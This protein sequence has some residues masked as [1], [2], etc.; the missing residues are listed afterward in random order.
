MSSIIKKKIKG[1]FDPDDLW[2]IFVSNCKK[3]LHLAL[4]MTPIGDQFRQRLRNFPSLINCTS[5][6]WVLPW[7]EE[8][9]TSV[10][11]HFLL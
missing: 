4:C 8:A 3:Y 5:I 1:K 2:E 11:N 9:L 7:G 6:L 10:A